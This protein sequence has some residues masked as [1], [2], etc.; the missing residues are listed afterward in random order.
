VVLRVLPPSLGASFTIT[1][2]SKGDN[3]CSIITAGGTV[4]CQ[5]DASRSEGFIASYRW[6]FRIADKEFNASV[7]EGSPVYTPQFDCTFLSG[8]TPSS[9]GTVLMLAVLRV[10]DREGT[11]SNPVQQTFE[12]TPNG[13]CGY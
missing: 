6:T 11:T 12:L 5:F 8:G 2:P 13:R 9:S 10:Q 4:D 7:P 1:S 3:A